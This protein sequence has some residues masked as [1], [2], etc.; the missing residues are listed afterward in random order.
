MAVIQKMR[1]KAGLMVVIIGIAMVLFLL[2]DLLTSA[3]SFSE[4]YSVAGMV[5][6]YEIGTEEY[7]NYTGNQNASTDKQRE[8][9]HEKAWGEFV[10]RN[11]YKHIFDNV[12]LSYSEEE[13]NHLLYENVHPQVYSAAMQIDQSFNG[14]Y[15]IQYGDGGGA[16]RNM[17]SEASQNP[18]ISG[19]WDNFANYSLMD[20]R[21]KE[22]YRNLVKYGMFDTKLMAKQADVN[23]NRTYKVSF[24]HQ[25][26]NVIEEADVKLTDAELKAYYKDNRADFETE[27]TRDVKFVEFRI[28]ADVQD[29]NDTKDALL[30][31]AAEMKGMTAE[32][33][34]SY[35]QNIDRNQDIMFYTKEE[36]AD[37][38]IENLF[39]DE[40]AIVG[41]V[42]S[43]SK[44]TLYTPDIKEMIS[45][46][47]KAAHILI[48]WKGLQNA[49][50]QE[51]KTKGQ[52]QTIADSLLAVFEK[53]TAGFAK[54][55]IS[56]SRDL[57]SGAK[58]GNLGWFGQGRM[59]PA[60]NDACF[61]A[62]KRGE[63]K[64][65]ESRFGFHV[66]LV[67]KQSKKGE[68]V[69]FAKIDREIRA[70]KRTIGTYSL[71]ASRFA[72]GLENL[73]DFEEAILNDPTLFNSNKE[74]LT[75]MSFEIIGLNNP[76][77]MVI[78]AFQNEVGAVSTPFSF[79]NSFVVAA[80]SGASSDK[81]IAFEDAKDLITAKLM[82]KKR[83]EAL[84]A[85]M[86][87]ELDKA[88]TL[89]TLA[90]AFNLTVDTDNAASFESTGLNRIYSGEI[91]GRL[92]KANKGEVYGPFVAG[93]EVFAFRVDEVIVEAA[94]ANLDDDIS[95]WDNMSRKHASDKLLDAYEELLE[96]EDHREKVFVA[97][98]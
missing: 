9:I 73:G 66:I 39:E 56:L 74:G 7:S 18:Q 59:V 85:K 49:G 41:P 33:R 89:K 72:R 65:V 79:G 14:R 88:N 68:K 40:N 93:N 57:G 90:A 70:S 15:G 4:D 8:D 37:K 61:L 20:V 62:K 75:P 87:A 24:V 43:G 84:H 25:S 46:S 34:A 28:N 1:D 3:S 55:A 22:K 94:D 80:V 26:S 32:R 92:E 51:A 95:K 35:A 60:F 97:K 48:T 38:G 36:L 47:V 19:Y 12:N 44:W 29:I 27:P 96:V 23:N 16:I 91:L 86:K 83:G 50:P 11:I 10:Q 2:G 42:R 45:D 64:L 77:N 30:S 5:G 17:I 13:R 31:Y 21:K 53:D 67:Q 6:D 58:G 54:A 69:R 52:A 76:R 78:W 98:K 71:K 81:F 82:D 63:V